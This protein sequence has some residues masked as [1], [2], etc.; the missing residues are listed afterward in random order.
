MKH[1][2][3]FLLFFIL[4]FV[5]KA[6]ETVVN[7]SLQPGYADQV[8][9]KFATEA[10]ANFAA[11]SWE[12]AF[13][14]T[15]QFEFAT[16]INTASGIEVYEAA[17]DPAEFSTINPADIAN[18]VRLYNSDTTWKKG[19]FDQGSATYGWGEYNPSNHHVQGKIVYVLKYPDGSFKN[20][21]IDDFS[22]GY[23]FKYSTWDAASSSWGTA[24]TVTLSN[25][26]NQGKLFN[27]YN[28]TTGAAVQAAPNTAD[29][30]LVFTKYMTTVQGTPYPV[31]GALINP[32]VQVAKSLDQNA[33]ADAL[34]YA[35]TINTVGYNWKNFDMESM[36][37]TVN[38]DQYYFLKYADGT[39]Y[40][41]H[42]LSYGG[43][44]TGD[45]SLGYEDV[46]DALDTEVFT[47]GNSF[48]LY[49]NPTRGRRVSVLLD[50]VKATQVHLQIYS[51][52]G[53]VLRTM[54]FENSGFS[55]KDL[56]LSDLSSGVYFLK[57][58]IGQNST[59]KKLILN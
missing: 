19:A 17:N 58:T 38:S 32:D 34:V 42:F 6:Q 51:V 18:W 7:L 43:S 35:D 1:L 13:L 29:W 56:D 15:S 9:F 21:M 2:N 36:S 57:F 11:D 55:Q 46:T 31:T 44:S 49:P 14:R 23:T 52:Q 27:Y 25:T 40:R 16:R 33:T 22:N 3:S 54:S 10:D 5:A 50:N 26:D 48:N 59:T 41:F 30:D 47:K 37:Y 12:L 45:F 28:L 8:Y 4:A 39:V 24:D 20:F 53:K